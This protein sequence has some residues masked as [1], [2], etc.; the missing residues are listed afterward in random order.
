MNVVRSQ[1]GKRRAVSQSLELRMPGW[2]I[3]GAAQAPL[4]DDRWV[5]LGVGLVVTGYITWI[6][7]IQHI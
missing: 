6:I 3:T 4:P 5:A 1:Q 7:L 2:S